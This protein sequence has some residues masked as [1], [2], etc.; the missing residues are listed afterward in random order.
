MWLSKHSVHVISGYS[1]DGGGGGEMAVSQEELLLVLD[2]RVQGLAG[3]IVDL[4][5]ESPREPEANV[6]PRVDF[7]LHN[8]LCELGQL[9]TWLAK[10]ERRWERCVCVCCGHGC[11]GNVDSRD[12]WQGSS[13][14]TRTH[15]HVHTVHIQLTSNSYGIFA[16]T[17][18][19]LTNAGCGNSHANSLGIRRP[20]AC[21]CQN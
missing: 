20:F 21:R 17:S 10:D 11:A 12:K 9:R 19:S 16:V 18:T 4:D 14:Q 2:L 7:L 5:T 3:S 15:A 13:H 8:E 6:V 1:C